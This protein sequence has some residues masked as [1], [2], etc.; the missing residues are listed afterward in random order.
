MTEQS[1]QNASLLAFIRET[2]A[3]CPSCSYSLKGLDQ[4]RCPECGVTLRLSLVRA[5]RPWLWVY[6]LIGLI[7][8]GAMLA[9]A[10]GSLVVMVV[11]R[12]WFQYP[13]AALFGAVL[14]AA[15]AAQSFMLARWIGRRDDVS[16]MGAAIA[17]IISAGIGAV[18]WL[19]AAL[20]SSL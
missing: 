18:V 5:A 10:L 14:L 19:A 4:D 2:D 15:V 3:R 11:V 20:V 9:L 17:W 13:V 16:P 8:V 1:H 12:E 6:G 7:V